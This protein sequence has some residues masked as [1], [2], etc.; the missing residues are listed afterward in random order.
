MATVARLTLVYNGVCIA[1][2]AT[3]GMIK[4]SFA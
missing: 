3:L 2:A 4:R 1:A